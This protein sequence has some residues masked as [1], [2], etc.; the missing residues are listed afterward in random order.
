MQKL[1]LFKLERFLNTHGKELPVLS[2][3][4]CLKAKVT[5]K[6]INRN[7]RQSFQLLVYSSNVRTTQRQANVRSTKIP[8]GP[9]KSLAEP[10]Y[11]GYHLH[12]PGCKLTGN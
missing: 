11:F 3:L 5:L 1:L 6:K 10:K 12:I 9:P 2:T 7:R 8:L 4:I